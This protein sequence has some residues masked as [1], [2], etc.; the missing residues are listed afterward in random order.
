MAVGGN[1]PAVTCSVTGC[2]SP[3]LARTYCG[4]HYQ[5]FRKHGDPE[6]VAWEYGGS[7]A[8][9][10][11]RHVPHQPVDGCWV[12]EGLLD[13]K[14]YGETRIN[15]IKIGTHRASYEHFVGP[16]PD[17]LWVLHTCTNPPCCNPQ[18]LYAGTPTD[19]AQD[20]AKDGNGP[21]RSKR[22]GRFK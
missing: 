4:K 9:R 21:R 12:W 14:G 8:D 3:H 19:N 18:H 6:R 2:K 1:D 16:I 17:G 22:T 20:R 13:H 5:R 10:L 11:A 15:S 7:F